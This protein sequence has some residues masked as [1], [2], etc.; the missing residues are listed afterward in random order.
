[1][2]PRPRKATDEAVFAAA[3]R[4]MSR[5]T[6]Q[7]LT[8]ADIAA[9]AGLT[10][11]ALV[12]R[13]GSKRE[14]LLLLV[15]QFADAVPAM[16]TEMRAAHASPLAALRAY[17]ECFGEMAQTPETLAHHL[18][19]LQ[20]DLTDPDF[21]PFAQAQAEATRAT[22]IAWLGEA[23]DAGELPRATDVDELARMTYTV[24]SGALIAW[25]FFRDGTAGTCM[26][27][28]LDTLL[29]RYGAPA[30]TRSGRSAA[31]ARR[32]R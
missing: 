2:S 16:M 6:P 31:R 13:Y 14:L 30:P 8:L 28:D 26:R 20:V 15:A 18:G 23:V 21:F 17:V 4:V 25:A 5:R 11:G 9:E 3:Y 10:A 7:E 1:V 32:K 27:R 19:W 24:M 12:A 29:T 22:F